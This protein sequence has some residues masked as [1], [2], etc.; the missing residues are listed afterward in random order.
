MT[1]EEIMIHEDEADMFLLDEFDNDDTEDISLVENLETKIKVEPMPKDTT[2]PAGWRYKRKSKKIVSP[3][4]EVFRSR[5]G[6]LKAM[7][8]SE[9]YSMEEIEEMRYMLRHERWR[10]SDD[11]PRCWM[12][13]DGRRKH[14]SE[15]L[16]PGG[17][18]FVSLKKVSQFICNY[19]EYFYTEDLEQFEKVSNLDLFLTL[20]QTY[21]HSIFTLVLYNINICN[22]FRMQN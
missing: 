3:N 17:E 16:G 20:V 2:V 11:L 13:R 10:E 19:E 9:N 14:G 1:F 12:I 8:N 4:G 21:F 15:F 7:V 22:H 5:R 6:A 18:F